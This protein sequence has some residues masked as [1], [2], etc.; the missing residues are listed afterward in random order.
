MR[1]LILSCC[2]ISASTLAAADPDRARKVRVALAL[3][4]TAH[5]G[6]C[7]MDEPEARAESLLA[8]KPLV[9][10]VGPHCRRCGDDV[11]DA[12]GVSCVVDRYEGDGQPPTK[13]RA[14][15]L[16]PK[17]DGSGW[18]IAETLVDPTETQIRK[19]VGKLTGATAAARLNWDF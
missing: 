11:R 12:G 17:A 1:F 15:I 3:A 16:T 4:G 6:A 7:Q 10:F 5:C 19:A 14:V 2:L 18:W 13:T 8:K 9:L